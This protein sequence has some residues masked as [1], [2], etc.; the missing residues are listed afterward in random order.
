MFIPHKGK[1][2]DVDGAYFG[3]SFPHIFLL[4]N[5]ELVPE[6]ESKKHVPK[7]YGFRIFGWNGSKYHGATGRKKKEKISTSSCEQRLQ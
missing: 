3:V 6:F 2:V 4:S 5:P 1:G 7:I